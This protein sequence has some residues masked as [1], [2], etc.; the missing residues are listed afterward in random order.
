LKPLEIE[1]RETRKYLTQ[2]EDDLSRANIM[3][4]QNEAIAEESSKE[5]ARLREQ[6]EHLQKM[7][8][9]HGFAPE[10]NQEIVSIKVFT[11]AMV[12][13]SNYSPKDDDLSEYAFSSSLNLN[14]LG[15]R[16]K[17]PSKN[18]QKNWR[19]LRKQK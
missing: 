12:Q 18:F 2:M 14:N 1:L 3:L 15:F 5:V 11:D 8:M 19:L 13:T 4:H 9:D 6:N 10:V 7:L 16:M 17:Y